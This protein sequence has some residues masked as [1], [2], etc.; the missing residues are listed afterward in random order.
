MSGMCTEKEKKILENS[1]WT[2]PQYTLWL[3]AHSLSLWKEGAKLGLEP[4]IN[5]REPIY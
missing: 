4:L 2:S 5:I 1:D 3:I